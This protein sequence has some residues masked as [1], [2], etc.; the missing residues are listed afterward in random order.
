MASK[1][2]A[3]WL[4]ILLLLS[5]GGLAIGAR[6]QLNERRL[7]AAAENHFASA[8]SCGSTEGAERRLVR[9]FILSISNYLPEPQRQ[10]IG[11]PFLER[12]AAGKEDA[13]RLP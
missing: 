9:S 6:K 1:F 12:L 3:V 10:A 4:P 13:R 11:T 8:R 5:V 2:K 7:R